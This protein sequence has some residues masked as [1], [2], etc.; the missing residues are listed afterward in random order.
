MRDVAYCNFYR[1][2]V[3][4]KTKTEG[5]DPHWEVSLGV[6]PHL[7]CRSVRLSFYEN[8]VD[9]KFTNFCE[10]RLILTRKLPNYFLK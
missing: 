3:V 8:K 4:L 7:A 9:A 10:V 5:A 1:T 2:R 6:W